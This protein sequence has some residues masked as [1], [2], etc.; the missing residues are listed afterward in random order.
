MKDR[1]ADSGT[2]EEVPVPWSNNNR[3]WEMWRAELKARIAMSKD[4]FSKK[5]ELLS[6][7][8]S[9]VVKKKIVKTR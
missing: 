9:R 8:I 5:K 4:A 1:G 7:N 3:E 2:S 6:R